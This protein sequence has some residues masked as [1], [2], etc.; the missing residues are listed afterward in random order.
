MAGSGIG[1]ILSMTTFGESHGKAIGVILD[2]FP[3][4]MKLK[5][6]D[7]MP[8]LDRR[9]PGK[10]VVSTSR[11]ESDEVEILSGVFHGKTTGSPIA[12]VIRNAD[13][14]DADYAALKD[15]YRPGHADYTFDAKYGLRDHLG[16]G[17]S[18]GRETAARVAAGAVCLKLLKELGIT[19]CAYTRSIGDCEIDDKRFKKNNI[20]K[21]VTAMPDNVADQRATELIANARAQKNSL[22]GVVECIIDGVPAGIGDPVFDKLDARF[23]Q[24]IMSIG[25]VKAVELGDGVA[26]S[27]SNGQIF[28]DSFAMDEDEVIKKTNHAGGILGGISDGDRIILRAHF[29]PTPSISSVQKTVNKKGKETS[30]SVK[31]RH[32]PVVVPR[33]VVVVECMSAFVLLDAMLRNMS[34]KTTSVK[35]FYHR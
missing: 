34:A 21:N 4:G 13:V 18:S 10:S 14:N 2:G 16:G 26:A 6:S 5:E 33:A 15:V 28:N 1:T 22:G 11:K 9:R 27:K 12:M 31:G 35:S 3:A 24:A 32:D 25:A 8:Y 17:R 7:I 19:V 23:A 30:L 29:K 20:Y